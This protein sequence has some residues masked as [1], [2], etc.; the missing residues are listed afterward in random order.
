MK[1][2]FTLIFIL[3]TSAKILFGQQVIH[4][5][6]DTFVCLPG[7]PVPLSVVIDSGTQGTL[8]SIADDIY[9]QVID[10]GFSFTYFGNTYTQCVLSTNAYISFNLNN[11]LQYSQWPISNA[12]P[13][14]SN[15]LN[16][17][18]GPWHDVDPAVPPF[19]TMGYG[20]FGVAPDRF[21]VFNFC[22]VPMFWCNDT[23]FTGQIILYEGSNNIEI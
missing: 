21:F 11:A 3:S 14:P 10:I 12:A 18:Y 16:S 17:I 20:T 1:K 19:G 6:C 5:C 8:L 4:A 9:S 7:S 22:G 15:P 13:S 23:L 2:F